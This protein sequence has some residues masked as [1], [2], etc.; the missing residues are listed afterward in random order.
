MQVQRTWWHSPFAYCSAPLDRGISSKQMSGKKSN[1]FCIM[2]SFMCNETGTVKWLIF[3]IGKVK[4]L[5][6]FGKKQVADYGFQYHNNKTAWMTW[7]FFEEWL[8]E[9]DQNFCSKWQH[10]TLTLDNFPGH[11]IAYQPTNIEL[12]YFN[13]NSLH[14]FIPLMQESSDASRC[15][16]IMLVVHVQ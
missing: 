3:Y 9:V 4:Q 13:P 6:C 14:T 7:K 16:I 15:T 2:V 1:K 11:M 8:K 10:V 12:I 5:R